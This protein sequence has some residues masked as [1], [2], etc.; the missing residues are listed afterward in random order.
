MFLKHHRS[1]DSPVTISLFNLL[2]VVD[3]LRLRS[4]MDNHSWLFGS[5]VKQDQLLLLRIEPLISRLH[6]C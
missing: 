5:L 2:V 1:C 3:K 6:S 4:S